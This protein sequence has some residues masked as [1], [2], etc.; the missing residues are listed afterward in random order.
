MKA[1][2]Y[3]SA[4]V[5]FDLEITYGQLNKPSI[6]FSPSANG[7]TVTMTAQAGATIWYTEGIGGE[8]EDPT[9]ELADS[10]KEYTGPFVADELLIDHNYRAIALA[11]QML[12][13]PVAPE[14]GQSNTTTP[15]YAPSGLSVG[16]PQ[17]DSL[18]VSWN[19]VAWSAPHGTVT[20][21]VD[22][23]ADPS[24]GAAVPLPVVG[25]S[26]VDIGLSGSTQYWYR[27]HAVR[28]M[29]SAVDSATVSGTTATGPPVSPTGLTATSVTATTID[30][31]WNAVA[32]ASEY[33]IIRDSG[34]PEVGT[35]T[36]PATTFTD[37]GLNSGIMYS[38]EVVASNVGGDSPPSAPD[39][40]LTFP[41]TPA[42]LT[43]ATA[44]PPKVVSVT[45]TASA[46]AAAYELWRDNG[47]G[48][49]IVWL[50]DVGAPATSYTDAA[51][52]EYRTYRYQILAKNGSPEQKSALSTVASVLT[53]RNPCP[54][55]NCTGQP[56]VL[57]QPARLWAWGSPCSGAALCS[58]A[59][60][61][62]VDGWDMSAWRL[63]NGA[64]WAAKPN[65]SQW[66]DGTLVTCASEYFDPVHDH[67]DWNDTEV[68]AP[69]G[70][71]D[72]LWFV[73]NP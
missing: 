2:H 67:C 56:W 69:N 41:A 1:Q 63:P 35:V 14:S 48:G 6:T 68:Q 65:K 64:D 27:V 70:G 73:R 44:T 11:P 18:T 52:V 45:W 43:P 32:G 72:E 3:P 55:D 34:T 42:N 25:T 71:S 28:G 4:M 53:S 15:D 16:S 66:G 29:A 37:T 24:F 10:E 58:T 57:T 61:S 49:A 30:L 9:N 33:K 17:E 40:A 22:R 46:G 8:P 38:Y 12:A 59:V 7:T 20:Y 50:T 13:S 5:E 26:V 47:L 36:A 21:V 60:E 19:P 31:S 51:T 39:S 54:G 23:A 62:G